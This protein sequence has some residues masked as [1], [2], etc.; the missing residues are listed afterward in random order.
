MTTATT[1]VV[2]DGDSDAGYQLARR[3]LA[4]GRRVAVVARHPAAAVRILHGQSADRVMVVGAD[5]SDE[6]Q[7]SRI[8]ERVMARFGRIDDVVRA[9]AVTLRATA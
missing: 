3:L 2:L 4:Q 9:E 6:R 5:A 7:W 1:T 8:V